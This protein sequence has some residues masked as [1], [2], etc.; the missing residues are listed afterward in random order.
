M[1]D[2]SYDST[3]IKRQDKISIAELLV[4]NVAWRKN[5]ELGR[6]EALHVRK[7]IADY[8]WDETQYHGK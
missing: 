6:G 3:V 5:S 7:A 8:F 2:L 4:S 1:F